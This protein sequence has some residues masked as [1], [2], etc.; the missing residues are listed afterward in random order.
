MSKLFAPCISSP[1]SYEIPKIKW[2]RFIGQ[3]FPITSKEDI[4]ELSSK[5]AHEHPGANHHCWAARYELQLQTDLFGTQSIITKHNHSSDD[6]EPANTA[7]KPILQVLEKQNI[8]NVLLVVTRY[9]WGT[10]LGVGW[11]IQAYSECAKHTLAH[12]E[13]GEEEV[14]SS[15]QISYPFEHMQTIRHLVQ[16]YGAKMSDEIYNESARC[17]LHINQWVLLEFRQE[18]KDATK[19]EII[20]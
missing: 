9:F 15:I 20:L 6:G 16:K 4:D 18:L 3:V 11:L 13:L 2:S 17:I 1:S 10:L 14:L 7:G 12:A 8:C 5:V 19:G